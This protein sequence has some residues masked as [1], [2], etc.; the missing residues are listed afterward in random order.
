MGDIEL[1]RLVSGFGPV[2]KPLIALT[3]PVFCLRLGSG[4]DRIAITTSTGVLCHA[5][6]SFYLC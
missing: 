4:A 6:T 5:L 1:A 2:F 3:V